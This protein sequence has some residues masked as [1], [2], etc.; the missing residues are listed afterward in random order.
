MVTFCKISFPFLA[1]NSGGGL[2]AGVTNRRTTKTPFRRLTILFGGC[3]GIRISNQKHPQCPK[4]PNPADGPKTKP[5]P[6]STP[7]TPA[8]IPRRP[9]LTWARR[10]WWRPSLPDAIRRAACAPSRASPAAS[11]P[12]ATP[13]LASR[14]TTVA[15]ESTGNYWISACDLLEAAGLGSPTDLPPLVPYAAASEVFLVNARHVKG[16]PGK[17][18]DVCDAQWLQQLHAAGLLKKSFRPTQEIVPLRYLMRHREGLIA[19]SSRQ[20]QRMQKS[21]P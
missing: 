17:K 6:A 8:S 14:I 21:L 20:I 13:L 1:K 10:N 19:G 7:S 4:R 18:T 5:V 2:E 15:L 3:P 16:V 9:G 12:C 11:K